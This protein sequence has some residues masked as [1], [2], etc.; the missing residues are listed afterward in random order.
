MSAMRSSTLRWAALAAGLAMIVFIT[1]IVTSTGGSSSPRTGPSFTLNLDPG[2][3]VPGRAPD[4]TLTDQFGRPVSL[5]QF[6]GSVVILAFNDSQCTTVCP[7][8]TTAMV[9]AK[10]LLGAAGS[11]V[12]L[13]GI[14]AN[15]TATAIKDVLAYSQVHGMTREWDF[16]TG[17]L[18]ALRRVWAGYHIEVEIEHGQI[19]HTPALFVIGPSGRFGKVYLTQMSYDSIDQQAQLL[20]QEASSLLPGHPRVDSSLSYAEVP[21]IAPTASVSLPGAAG[22]SVRLG[23]GGPRL[24]AFFATWDS[25]VTDLGKQL[26]ALGRYQ[27]AARADRLPTLTAVDEGSVEPSPAALG[28]F[29][30]R[31]GHP[32]AYPVAIDRTG[33]VADGYEV[34]DEPWLVLVSSSGRILWY[35][36]VSTSGWLSARAL[37]AQ[38]RAALTRTGTIPSQAAVAAELAGSPAPLAG[39]HRQASMLLGGE[40]ALLAR[41]R[42]LRGYPVVLNA[43]ASWC[44]PCR[45]E[46]GLFASASARYGREVAFLG[47]DTNDSP[48]DARAFLSQH[49]VSYPSYQSSITELSSLAAIEGLPTTIFIDRAGKVVY[50]HTGQYESQGTLDADIANYAH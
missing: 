29:L 27:A 5:H 34:Q 17:S 48:G 13:L 41:L 4:F 22:S 9:D 25:E 16:L 35:Y 28:R 11:R 3:A 50:V 21:S 49:R 1:L 18:G 43:W 37:V 36:D 6:R 32:L 30:A 44:T 31:L 20:A 8:T 40:Q 23:P 26:E 2:T 45:S 39:L 33:R 38:V 47:N 14:D 7:L 42:A 24:L 19:D 12:R 10:R 15:P 46:F